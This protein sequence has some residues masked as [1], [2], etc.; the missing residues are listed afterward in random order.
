[1]MK[2]IVCALLIHFIQRRIAISVDIPV[3]D[4][5]LKY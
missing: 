2:L 3:L 5:Q 1:M 4:N